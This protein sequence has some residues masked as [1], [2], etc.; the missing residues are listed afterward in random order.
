LASLEKK[1]LKGP[2]VGAHCNAVHLCPPPSFL[3][4]VASTLFREN[5][6]LV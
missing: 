4:E 6:D 5:V 1:I 2:W 3:L